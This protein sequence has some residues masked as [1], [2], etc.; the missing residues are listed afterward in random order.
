MD[1]ELG[2]FAAPGLRLP[3]RRLV[4]ADLVNVPILTNPRLSHLYQTV[5]DWFG[6]AG[7]APQRINTCNSLSIMA[8][9][10]VDGFGVAPL[11][12]ALVTA[13]LERGALRRL[14]TNPGLPAGRVM[15]AYR[16][17]PDIGN[18][19]GIVELVREVIGDK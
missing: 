16:T 1:I 18:L 6:A 19:T 11:P 12:C 13:E 3:R 10:T 14:Q 9:L 7:L 17:D 4:P 2:W 5:H 15:I 8:K